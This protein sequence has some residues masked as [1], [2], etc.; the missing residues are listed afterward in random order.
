MATLHPAAQSLCSLAG[1]SAERKRAYRWKALSRV[2]CAL[3]RESAFS[4]ISG[5]LFSLAI[6]GTWAVLLL[7]WKTNNWQAPNFRNALFSQLQVF[8]EWEN[9]TV[10]SDID[11]KIVL[12]ARVVSFAIGQK[13]LWCSQLQDI[14]E[15]SSLLFRSYSCLHTESTQQNLCAV[16]GNPSLLRMSTALVSIERRSREEWRCSFAVQILGNLPIFDECFC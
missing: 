9:C 14:A 10:A 8:R 13:E 4:S 7:L 2:S 5:A 1:F 15:I 16:P 3:A 11:A 6:N 12:Y